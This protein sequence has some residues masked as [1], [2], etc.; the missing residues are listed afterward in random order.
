MSGSLRREPG[1][2]IG[3]ALKDLP[4]R[5]ELP[6]VLADDKIAQ[7]LGVSS[8][9]VSIVAP[10]SAFSIPAYPHNKNHPA[11]TWMVATGVQ[12]PRCMLAR[13]R[14]HTLVQSSSRPP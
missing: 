9:S 5:L 12:S 13:Q 2:G 11:R 14:S 6:E 8:M 7:P 1:D 3:L 10:F 4:L